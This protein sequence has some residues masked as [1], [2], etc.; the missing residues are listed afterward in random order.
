MKKRD[1]FT[2]SLSIFILILLIY[3]PSLQDV[4][5]ESIADI[6]PQEIYTGSAEECYSMNVVIIVDQSTSMSGGIGADSQRYDANDPNKRRVDAVYNAMDWLA[7]NR[8]GTCQDAIYRIGVVG[9]GRDSKTYISLAEGEISPNN[10]DEWGDIF[11]I[12]ESKYFAEDLGSTDHKK[13]FVAAKGLFSSIEPEGALPWKNVIILITDGQP[14]VYSVGSSAEAQEN[15]LNDLRGYLQASFPFASSILA[16][17]TA[18]QEAINDYG[19]L[20]S[21]PDESFNDILAS[22]P[23][24]S[25]EYENSY[26][27]YIMALNDA[28]DY[29]DH[30]GAIFKQIAEEHGGELIDLEDNE[31]SVMTA[32]GDILGWV[33]GQESIVVSCDPIAVNPYLSGVSLDFYK[34]SSSIEVTI[35]MGSNELKYGGDEFGGVGDS[36]FWGVEG[37]SSY[38]ATEHYLFSQPPG[39]IWQFQTDVC[40]DIKAS[41]KPFEAD[42]EFEEDELIYPHYPS[43]EQKFDPDNPKYFEFYIEDT[44]T[45]Q[46]LMND[47]DYPLNMIA[48]IIMPGGTE[49]QVTFSFR[50]EDNRWVSDPLPVY[51]KGIASFLLIGKAECV[52]YPSDFCPE[53]EFVVVSLEG[54]Y[55]ISEVDELHWE[56]VYP[57]SGSVIGLHGQP[58]ELPLLPLEIEVVTYGESIEAPIVYSEWIVSDENPGNVFTAKLVLPGGEMISG[59]LSPMSTDPSRFRYTFNYPDD[60]RFIA[61][62]YEL[63]ITMNGVWQHDLYFLDQTQQTIVFER[64]DPFYLSKWFWSALEIL[65][66][67]ILAGVVGKIIYDHTNVVTGNLTFTNISI[68]DKSFSLNK[69]KRKVVIKNHGGLRDLALQKI[70]VENVSQANGS[71]GISVL[72]IRIKGTTSRM[73]LSETRK[74]NYTDTTNKITWTVTFAG[75][76]KPKR[77][78]QQG[79]TRPHHQ[80]HPSRRR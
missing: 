75:G 44:N 78:P 33:A 7:S 57:S 34:L 36:S 19:G 64:R 50:P 30:V 73:T 77:R 65:G 32:L 52:G 31:V 60:E 46:P 41:Y 45:G 1:F 37:Y 28:S 25:E 51:E 18:L 66:A 22:T 49:E 63:T 39:G 54:E 76:K 4:F 58:L 2:L 9:F 29:L 27:I 74:G 68:G 55:Q 24:T 3:Y 62:E 16:R 71:V 43:S 6:E 70:I 14:Y 11:D 48:E 56:I 20:G 12:F 10:Y 23:V 61:G 5:A 72:L 15:Y 67:I 69:K 35:A 8:I 13:G 53:P 59:A 79:R 21:I 47:E 26:Y 17:D 80:R 42:I 38:G 40:R